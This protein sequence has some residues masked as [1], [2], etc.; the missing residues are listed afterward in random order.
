LQQVCEYATYR[1]DKWGVSSVI[2]LSMATAMGLLV[3]AG[4]CAVKL[5]CLEKQ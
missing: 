5:P 1:F 3:A 2:S 4:F